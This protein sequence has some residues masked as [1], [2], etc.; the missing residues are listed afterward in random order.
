MPSAIV[1]LRRRIDSTL[2]IYYL[3]FACLLILVILSATTASASSTTRNLDLHDQATT[4]TFGNSRKVLMRNKH[5]TRR[6]INN[7]NIINNNIDLSSMSPPL[8][9]PAVGITSNNAAAATTTPTGI[10]IVTTASSSKVDEG[11]TDTDT[12]TSTSGRINKDVWCNKMFAKHKVVV[13][14]SFGSLSKHQ[15]QTWMHFNCDSIF[16]EP[17]VKA[18]R[19]SYTCVP[20]AAR[21]QF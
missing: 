8:P 9:P 19:G 15:Q 3:S 14:A 10:N 11:V 20:L 7:H 4:L 17:H 12:D 2:L 1:T 16:C 21:Q 5:N 18:G 13:G 6:N